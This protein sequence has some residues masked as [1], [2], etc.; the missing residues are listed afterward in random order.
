MLLKKGKQ[1]QTMVSKIDKGICS[2]IEFQNLISAE[3]VEVE[4][5]YLTGLTFINNI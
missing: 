3:K 5:V 4:I 1:E 2:K